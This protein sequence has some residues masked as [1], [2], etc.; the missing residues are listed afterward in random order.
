MALMEVMMQIATTSRASF[1][2][3]WKED[4][5]ADNFM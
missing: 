2:N 3:C 4:M 1:R 5:V